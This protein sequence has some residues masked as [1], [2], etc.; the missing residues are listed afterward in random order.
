MSNTTSDITLTIKAA[1]LAL[2]RIST[3]TMNG[4]QYD[5]AEALRKKLFSLDCEN[6]PQ[7]DMAEYVEIVSS[8]LLTYPFTLPTA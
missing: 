2:Y 5:R 8:Y 4:V 3:A 6:V 1:R 7:E